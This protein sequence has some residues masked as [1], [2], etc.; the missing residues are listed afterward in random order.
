MT[1]DTYSL[2]NNTYG[3]VNG[4]YKLTIDTDSLTIDNY[5]STI[6][7]YRITIETYRMTLNTYCLTTNNLNGTIEDS[8]I[9]ND[10][11]CANAVSFE[12]AMKKDKHAIESAIITIAVRVQK[13]LGAF[14]SCSESRYA[15]KGVENHNKRAVMIIN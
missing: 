1:K 5:R 11:L 6:D 14:N 10:T 2:T 3:L 9:E 7:K 13:I 8:M 12:R 15:Y 4:T